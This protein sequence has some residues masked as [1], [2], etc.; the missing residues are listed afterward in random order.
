MDDADRAKEIEMR[1]RRAALKMAKHHPEPAQQ[2][3]DDEVLCIDCD[4]PVSQERLKAKPNA[5][6]CIDCQSLHEMKGKHH[7]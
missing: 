6:R 5:A 3:I 1:D 2:I 4:T 7:A